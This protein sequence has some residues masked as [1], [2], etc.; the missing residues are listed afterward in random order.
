MINDFFTHPMRIFFLLLPLFCVL[1]SFIFFTNLDF[2][3]I[4]KTLFIGVIPC[5]AYCGFLLTAFLDWTK[6]NKNLKPHAVILFC[7]LNLAFLSAFFNTFLAN[8]FVAFA[9]TYICKVIFKI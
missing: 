8:L 5:A 4:H 2:I 1:S 9:W 3:T 7:I 6:F